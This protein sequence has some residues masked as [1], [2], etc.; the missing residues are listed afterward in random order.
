M[1][2]LRLSSRTS[3]VKQFSR[4]ASNNFSGKL[5]L[6]ASL[7]RE[8]FYCGDQGGKS[9]SESDD[10]GSSPSSAANF[11]V[12]GQVGHGAVCKTVVNGF[13]SR[14]HFQGPVADPVF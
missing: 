10:A 2:Q 1:H 6:Y 14:P 4:S 12:R 13:E 11:M 9:D 3:R 8:S 7:A 5:L